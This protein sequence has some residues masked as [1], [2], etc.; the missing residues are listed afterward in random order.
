MDVVRTP[1]VDLAEQRPVLRAVIVEAR[2]RVVGAAGLDGPTVAALGEWA[3]EIGYRLG[4]DPEVADLIICAAGD[5]ATTRRLL[6]AAARRGATAVVGG[7]GWPYGRRDAHADLGSLSESERARFA[8]RLPAVGEPSLSAIPSPIAFALEEGGPGNGV[9]TAVE[10]AVREAPEVWEVQL[11]TGFGGLAVLLPQPLASP[12]AWA[13]ILPEDER[14][15]AVAR[16]EL[17]NLRL[18]FD[19]ERLLAEL[20]AGVVRLEGLLH[21]AGED[22]PVTGSI[23]VDGADGD[24]E[25]AL[26]DRME[27]LADRLARVTVRHDE[28][29]AALAAAQA[30]AAELSEHLRDSHRLQ[31]GQ[32]EAMAAVAGQLEESLRRLDRRDAE[33]T[34]MREAHRDELAYI[35]RQATAIAASGAWRWGHRFAVARSRMLLRGGRGT[36][37]V[38]RLLERVSVGADRR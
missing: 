20:G 27:I 10:D 2:P 19:R 4:G 18:R 37:A 34:G 6:D 3:A 7:T 9:R 30:R 13:R 17:A 23:H 5:Y 29:A 16:L 33:L 12:E 25:G 22:R 36:D 31:A 1:V 14:D 15:R 24:P 28:H 32:E 26:A 38:T 35:E 11:L 8:H 21:A